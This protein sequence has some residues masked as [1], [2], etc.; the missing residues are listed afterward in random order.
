MS[1]KKGTNFLWAPAYNPEP[2]Q[3]SGVLDLVL[4]DSFLGQPIRCKET[5]QQQMIIKQSGVAI[6][7]S[8]GG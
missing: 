5:F 8:A 7:I 4:R 1:P 2:P 6:K 3:S